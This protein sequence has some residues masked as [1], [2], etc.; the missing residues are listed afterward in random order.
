MSRESFSLN[1]ISNGEEI[2]SFSICDSRSSGYSYVTTYQGYKSENAVGNSGIWY[3]CK[4]GEISSVLDPK[5]GKKIDKSSIDNS[6][7]NTYKFE[8]IHYTGGDRYSGETK[9]GKRDGY[10]IYY[11]ND[12][13]FWLGQW[14]DGQRDGYGA[15]FDRNK[16]VISTGKWLGDT[17]VF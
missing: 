17:K 7:L 1:K 13:R 9:N 14:K 8:T 6:I 12:G 16:F 3:D 15:L 4:T 5:T 10:G 11:F 2:F